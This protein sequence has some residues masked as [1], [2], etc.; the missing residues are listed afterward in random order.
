MGSRIEGPGGCVK[1]IRR[2]PF[3]I[4]INALA[5]P[6]CRRLAA[7]WQNGLG[8]KEFS[9]ALASQHNCVGKDGGS[10]SNVETYRTDSKTSWALNKAFREAVHRGV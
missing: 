10:F 7:T 9:S 3:P 8:R 1:C 5:V 4:V 2:S 6:Q